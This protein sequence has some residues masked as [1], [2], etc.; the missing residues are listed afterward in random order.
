MPKAYPILDE[1]SGVNWVVGVPNKPQDGKFFYCRI[2]VQDGDWTRPV[3]QIREKLRVNFPVTPGYQKTITEFPYLRR[4]IELAIPRKYSH[5]H[6]FFAEWD[7]KGMQQVQAQQKSIWPKK[8]V[9][10]LKD[11]LSEGRFLPSINDS[12]KHV[13]KGWDPTMRTKAVPYG[14][15]KKPNSKQTIVWV[16]YTDEVTG[17]EKSRR[18]TVDDI[19][20]GD[21]LIVSIMV[22]SVTC[23]KDEACYTYPIVECAVWKGGQV[24]AGSLQIPGVDGGSV[25][26]GEHFRNQQDDRPIL[27][28]SRSSESDGATES[29]GNTT[30]TTS[31]TTDAD[32]YEFED[33]PD[34]ISVPEQT[35]F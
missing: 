8:K 29:K 35:D 32:D 26:I 9:V 33:E 22:E 25:T 31:S 21:E 18:G 17:R 19:E 6:K 7:M 12:D 30:T 11:M 24:Q 5:I 2:G 1:L 13:E 34:D 4:N 15:P 23:G 28:R 27:K 20:M 3:I 10:A 16:I 14:D